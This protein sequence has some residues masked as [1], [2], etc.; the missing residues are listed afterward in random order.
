MATDQHPPGSSSRPPL[1]R[2]GDLSKEQRAWMPTT[3]WDAYGQWPCAS[4]AE[5]ADRLEFLTDAG[6]WDWR[7]VAMAAR[8]YPG[9][10]VE[11]RGEGFLTITPPRDQGAT[12]A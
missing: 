11:L 5:L 10:R 3:A 8:A 6:G 9:W 12:D 2:D 7:S 1:V 4:T